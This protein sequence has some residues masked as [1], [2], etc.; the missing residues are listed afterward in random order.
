MNKPSS[1]RIRLLVT[2]L[3]FNVGMLL[4]SSRAEAGTFNHCSC[5]VAGG[6]FQY[7]CC[8]F[9]CNFPFDTCCG[10]AGDCTSSHCGA[11]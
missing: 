9:A 4:S 1:R 11:S 7:T 5:C 6:G 2:F 8:A 3:A 10:A